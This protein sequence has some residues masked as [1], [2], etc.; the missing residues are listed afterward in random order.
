MLLCGAL[1]IVSGVWLGA[2]ARLP[3]D[4]GGWRKLWQ[5]LGFML[6]LFGAIQFVGALSGGHDWMRPLHHLAGGGSG[7]ASQP[8]PEFHR[9]ENLEQLQAA[10][11]AR[12]EEHT[13]ELQSRG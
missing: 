1:A 8:A 13:S 6:L 4:V 9:V 11:A 7:A 5:S 2:L 3:A 10:V 12:S